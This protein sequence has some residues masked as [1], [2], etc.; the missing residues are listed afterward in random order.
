[1]EDEE[2]WED[3]SAD[4]FVWQAML[5]ESGGVEVGDEAVDDWDVIRKVLPAGWEEQARQTRAFLLRRPDGFDSPASLLR[6]MLMHL[7]AGVSLRLT[8]PGNRRRHCGCV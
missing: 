4:A 6:V 2:E 8:A 3:W 7:A 5:N 1:M